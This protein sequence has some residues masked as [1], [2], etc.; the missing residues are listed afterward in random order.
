MLAEN[1]AD[2]S[3]PLR[4]GASPIVL[5]DEGFHHPASPRGSGHAYTRYADLT[6]VAASPRALWVAARRSVVPLVRPLFVDPG[7]PERLEAALLARVA[8][9][10]GGAEQL[11]RMRELDAMAHEKRHPVATWILG[12][13]CLAGFGLQLLLGP[14]LFEVGYFSSALVADGDLWRALTAAL[15]HGS[16]LHLVVNLIGVF[17]F[18]SLVERALG[19]PRV[20][21]VMALSELGAMGASAV[22]GEGGVVGVSGV[23]AGL[24]G[25]LLFLEL[26]RR[27]QIPA[28]WRLPRRLLLMLIVLIP[29]QA[30]L[31]RSIPMIAGEAHI[32]GFVAGILA[33]ALLTGRERLFAPPPP[34]VR[35]GAT[36]AAIAT[37]ASVGLAAA[38]LVVP[39]D[40]LAEHAERL[41]RLPGMTPQE[42]NNYA[43]TIA[44]KPDS[45]RE[46]L[47][48]ALLLAERAVSTTLRS[49]PTLLDTLAEVQFQ[50]GRPDLAVPL[51]DEAIL[52]AP[53]EPYYREQRRRFTGERA[54]GDRPPD[55]VAPWN[56]DPGRPP[57]PP[58]EH[59]VTV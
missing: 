5:E 47:E 50:L 57:L 53:D 29:L 54:P 59:G 15:L 41:A 21:C 8:R 56:L 42:L 48:A 16:A 3:F 49:D 52:R 18:G 13:A 9:S 36:A 40:F 33:A 6:H 58:D 31:D 24:V 10:P 35:A 27:D 22:A 20:V 1:E 4:R 38:A 2:E 12:G 17:F 26:L 25:A 39:E 45:T 51:I 34:L 30:L 55:P 32:G 7:G 43:W 19:T 46:Q 23:L 14:E 37:L 11:E 44:I 28:W